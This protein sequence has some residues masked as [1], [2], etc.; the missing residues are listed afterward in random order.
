VKKVRLGIRARRRSWR[1]W[2]RSWA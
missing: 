1:T 2:S